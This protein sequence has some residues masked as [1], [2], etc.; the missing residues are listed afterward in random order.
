MSPPGSTRRRCF[1]CGW[2][3]VQQGSGVTISTNSGTPARQVASGGKVAR[4]YHPEVI[5][6]RIA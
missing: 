4:N 2:P 6:D 1:D 3:I 5:E